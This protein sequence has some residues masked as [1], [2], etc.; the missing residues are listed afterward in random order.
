MPSHKQQDPEDRT[1]NPVHLRFTTTQLVAIAAAL[2]AA[3][4]FYRDLK[5]ELS[6]VQQ[7]VRTIESEVQKTNSQLHTL[8]V[9][10]NLGFQD[11]LDL[12]YE[13][14]TDPKHRQAI[15]GY[16]DKITNRMITTQAGGEPPFGSPLNVE[17]VFK[18]SETVEGAIALTLTSPQPGQSVPVL[19]MN[20]GEV[21]T[22]E[23]TRGEEGFYT[24]EVLDKVSGYRTYYSRLGSVEQGVYVGLT[25]KRGQTL[26]T[27]RATSPAG[28]RIG[29]KKPGSDQISDP[30]GLMPPIE[31]ASLPLFE[32]L[33]PF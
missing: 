18:P 1:I 8:T 2:L 25:V 31:R 16:R 26:G 10:M 5:T 28:L 13:I 4:G 12:I 17:A 33:W 19:A 21:V 24:V 14:H 9:N 11:I 27:A 22:C 7:S 20:T 23:E 29:V 6:L 3:Y 32:W 30:R 15:D